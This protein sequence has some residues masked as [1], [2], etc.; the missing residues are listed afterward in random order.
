MQQADN[1]RDGQVSGAGISAQ[2]HTPRYRINDWQ[3]L[4][5]RPGHARL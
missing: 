4:M 3:R 2:Q 1:A 5:A